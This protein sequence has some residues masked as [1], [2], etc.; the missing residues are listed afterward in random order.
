MGA[1]PGQG[2]ATLRAGGPMAVARASLPQHPAALAGDQRLAQ[3]TANAPLT[4]PCRNQL[5][6]PVREYIPCPM[7]AKETVMGMKLGSAKQARRLAR[8]FEKWRRA[9]DARDEAAITAARREIDAFIASDETAGDVSAAGID[10][11]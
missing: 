9:F 2:P 6:Q 5:A 8:L 1:N 3:R 10:P 4:R 11:Q 7:T